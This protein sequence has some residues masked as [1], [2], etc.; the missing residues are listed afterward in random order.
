[1]ALF[2]TWPPIIGPVI[3]ALTIHAC[4]WQIFPIGKIIMGVS[5]VH[6]LLGA[7]FSPPAI[8]NLA[9]GAHDTICS[10]I[11]MNRICP[12]LVAYTRSHNLEYCRRVGI[13]ARAVARAAEVRK[14]NS[15]VTKVKLMN[16]KAT[17]QF[18]QGICVPIPLNAFHVALI[19]YGSVSGPLVLI[20]FVLDDQRI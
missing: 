6:A 14:A 10:T 17:R 5:V 15:Q 2:E 9:H 1:M 16:L 12:T 13:A 11:C 20:H 7:I 8:N 3:A 4:R 18:M 19:A